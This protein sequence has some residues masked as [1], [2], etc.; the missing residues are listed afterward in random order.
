[1]MYLAH[2][3][4]N[5]YVPQGKNPT[6]P[7][8]RGKIGMAQGWISIVINLLLF[9]IKL[10]FGIISNSIAL[11]TDAFH[12]LSDMASSAVVVFGF[13]MSSKPADKEH[14]FGHGRAETIAA[15]T[16]AILIGFA[17]IECLKTSIV[18]LMDNEKITVNQM[19]ITIVIIIGT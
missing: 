6:L 3:I 8:Y 7:Q 14:P 19:L 2:Y 1:M 13:K 17:G 18:R 11:I 4:L 5:R 12:S 9:G 16:I 10:V 15:L